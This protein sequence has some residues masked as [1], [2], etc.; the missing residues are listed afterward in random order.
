MD[1]LQIEFNGVALQAKANVYFDGKV[2]S[3]TFRLADGTRKTAG[4][5]FP[6]QFHFGTDA[7]ERM[8]ITDGECFVQLDGQTARTRY[9]A[10]QIFEVAAKSGFGIEVSAGLCQYVCTYLG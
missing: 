3:H 5:I 2:V 6:G 10:G 9:A 1:E 7:A 4:I 8:E